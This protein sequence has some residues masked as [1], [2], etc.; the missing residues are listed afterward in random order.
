MRTLIFLLIV[1]VARA[2]DW[3]RFLGPRADGTSSETN[4]ID[5]FPK[6]GPRILWEKPVGAGYSAPSIRTNPSPRFSSRPKPGP[7]QMVVVHHRLK[8][9]DL[10]T[11]ESIDANDGKSLWKYTYPSTFVDPFGYNN[12]PRCSPLLTEKHCYTFGAEG[13]LVCLELATGK[14][15]WQRDTGKEWTIPEAF[16]GVGSTPLM[17]GDT[18]IVMVGGQPNSGVVGLDPL[19]GK[20][21]WESVGEK[22][23]TGIP[24]TG[25]PG[26]RTVRWV[27]TEKQASYATPVAATVNG[28]RQIFCLMRQGL[29]SLNPTNGAVNFSFWFRS[30]ANDSVNASGPILIGNRVFISAAYYK[31]G[32]VLLEIQPDNKSVKEIWR[33]LSMEMHWSTPNYKDG[34]LYGFSGRNEPD[35]VFRAMEFNS[36]KIAWE[37]DERW[38]GHMPTSATFG[39]GSSVLADGKLYTLG[40]AGLLGIFQ[41]NPQKL[42]ELARWQVPSLHYPCWAAPILSEGKLYLRSEDRLVCVDIAKR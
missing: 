4:L 21:K 20:T 14:L 25:W 17:E 13:K 19:T 28:Q 39:R 41:P 8:G 37:R 15:L 23:W 36:G 7:E 1:V 12:G 33:G 42:E 5:S 34:Y 6:D 30:P 35:A 38:R 29:V 27:P 11:V 3:P 18:L 26:D 32:G 31:V 16:F 40:E 22:N 9:E 2:E 10:E 24:M